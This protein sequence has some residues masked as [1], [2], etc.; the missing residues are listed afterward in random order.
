MELLTNKSKLRTHGDPTPTIS[1][2]L[3]GHPLQ[4]MASTMDSSG[5]LRSTILLRK[6]YRKDN[7]QVNF[8]LYFQNILCLKSLVRCFERIWIIRY[9]VSYK[10]YKTTLIYFF[11]VNVECCFR[12]WQIIMVPQFPVSTASINS[13]QTKP[14]VS[15]VKVTVEKNN[16]KFLKSL[17][18]LNP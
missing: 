18:Y 16:S 3:G 9:Y 1:W 14:R 12:L 7:G 4:P 2:S 6:L 13:C 10:I 5:D 15:Q 11:C 8:Y 17:R